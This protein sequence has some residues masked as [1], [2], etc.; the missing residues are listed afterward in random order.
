VATYAI[1]DVQ[2]CFAEL[3]QLLARIGFAPDRDRLWFTGDLVNRGPGSLETLRYVRALGERA[4]TVL[5]NHDLHLLAVAEGFDDRRHHEDTL[6]E[7]LA[8]ADREELIAWLR[9][10]PLL[11][12]DPGLGYTL[13]H[14]G[15]PPQWDIPTAA[16]LAAEVE[17]VLRGPDYRSFF[18]RM[19]GDEPRVWSADLTGTARL[20]FITN[21]LTR[22]RFCSPD[23]A[24]ELSA[25]G[26][27]G[28]QRPG[29]VAWFEVPGRR[30]ARERIVFGHWSTLQVHTPVDPRHRV[31]PLDDGCLWGGQL[32]ALRL[33]DGACFE[34]PCPGQRRPSR[35]SASAA[36]LAPRS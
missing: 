9:G 34:L 31:Y 24:L 11:H 4:I 7:I 29:T 32:R 16:R 36:A 15:L 23:G 22:M 30:S 26:P 5:G 17:Q 33:E 20:R 27:P 19:Y 6:D 12:H 10:R 18:A 14:A 2:G 35:P 21:C 28:S 8:A 1:G 13:I 3:Q 25:K